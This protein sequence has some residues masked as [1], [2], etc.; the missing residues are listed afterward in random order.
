MATDFTIRD[1][2]EW[3]RTKPADGRYNYNSNENCALCQFLRETGRAKFP[4]LGSTFW[5]DWEL[6]YYQGEEGPILNI[7]REI[8]KAAHADEV[9]SH[10]TFGGLVSRLE[11]LC[12]DTPMPA[13]EWAA[14]DAYLT[15]IESVSA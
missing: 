15:D 6:G 5:S 12:P 11:T 10:W 3:A 2:L 7:P 9:P 14:I 8:D 1:V 4:T 13:S